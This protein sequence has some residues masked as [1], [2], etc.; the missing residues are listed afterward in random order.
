[1]R[2]G[3]ARPRSGT[4]FGAWLVLGAVF[5]AP[6]AAM[7]YIVVLADATESD[8][9]PSEGV[10]TASSSRESFL[11]SVDVDIA[12]T[13]SEPETLVAPSWAGLVTGAPELSEKPLANGARVAQIDGIWRVAAHTQR[14]FYAPVTRESADAQIEMLNGLLATLGYPHAAGETWGWD[15]TA[16][17]RNFADALNVPGAD[18]VVAFDPTWV[19]WMP[20]EQFDAAKTLLVV[21]TPAPAAGE[22]VAAGRALVTSAKIAPKG[23]AVLPDADA[24][25]AW[26]LVVGAVQSVYSGPELA[27]EAM[28]AVGA[29][30][31]GD[32]PEATTGVLRR[33]DA[34]DGWAIPAAAVVTDA[35][36]SLCVLVV[37]AASDT[38]AYRVVPVHSLGGSIGTVRV[39]GELDETTEVVAN[40]SRA[41]DEI[42]CS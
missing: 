23:G 5:I 4:H 7:A 24:P 32:M 37:D 35:S 6:I 14:P 42:R 41:L 39:V 15:T 33:H 29:S 19:V 2:R 9:A 18:S 3:K 27:N 17:V 1:M 12:L 8:V 36:G 11:D 16:G 28:A 34:V 30:L 25:D 26:D 22:S 31:Q 13:W 40:P 21:G 38:A 20:T 10:V